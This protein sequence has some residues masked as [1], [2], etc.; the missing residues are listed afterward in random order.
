MQPS[1]PQPR[2]TPGSTKS[3][4]I[5]RIALQSAGVRIVLPTPEYIKCTGISR[6]HS[7]DVHL[8]YILD[9]GIIH[10]ETLQCEAG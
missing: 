6:L 10:L 1:T 4:F 8:K 3:G 7:V 2:Y 5:T 9:Y